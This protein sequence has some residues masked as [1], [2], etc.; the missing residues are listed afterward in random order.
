MAKTLADLFSETKLTKAELLENAELMGYAN[1][2]GLRSLKKSDL[3]NELA[4]RILENPKVM[5]YGLLKYEMTILSMLAKGRRGKK[6]LITDSEFYSPLV[7]L[8]L[9]DI[10]FGDGNHFIRITDD[11]RKAIRPII[12]EVKEDKAYIARSVLEQFCLGAMNI[13]GVIAEHDLIKVANHCIGMKEIDET[14]FSLIAHSSLILKLNANLNP[15]EDEYYFKS[16]FLDIDQVDEVRQ[17][18][19]PVRLKKFSPEE[20]FRAGNLTD[21]KLPNP[22]SEQL[23]S[24]FKKKCGL[25]DLD[26]D[27]IM[28][29]TWLLM[30]SQRLINP[31]EI[32]TTYFGSITPDLDSKDFDDLLTAFTNYWNHLPQWRFKGR[33]AADISRPIDPTRPPKV[34]IGPNM[35]KMGYTQEDVD[36]M[37]AEAF[38]RSFGGGDAVGQAPMFSHPGVGRNDPCPCGS[39]KKFKNCCGRN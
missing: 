11:L 29:I 8:S 19:Q 16:P 18:Q 7:M 4:R 12:D 28:F 21:F 22:Y 1:R 6:I 9:V 14:L 35:R 10:E 27:K 38:S 32:I 24:L 2:P 39:G 5:L 25:G 15:D 20:Y 37:M 13:Y 33:C 26:V 36:E 31:I 23:Q 34:V 30:Q 3:C 17:G